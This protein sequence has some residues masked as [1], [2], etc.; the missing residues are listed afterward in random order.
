MNFSFRTTPF[1]AIS[2]LA[3]FASWLLLAACQKGNLDNLEQ[4][5]SLA[6]LDIQKI[7]LAV[8]EVYLNNSDI[9]MPINNTL[10]VHLIGVGNGN[11]KTDITGLVNVSWS[12]SSNNGSKISTNGVVTAGASGGSLTVNAS[13]A[14]LTANNP[15]S[16]NVYDPATLSST[17][18]DVWQAQTET[19][20]N[21]SSALNV[22]LCDQI[23]FAA[24]HVYGSYFWPA[25]D[26]NLD[27]QAN[28]TVGTPTS[29]NIINGV[30]TTN[31]SAPFTFNIGATVANSTPPITGSRTL[32]GTG[33]TPNSLRIE[34]NSFDVLVNENKALAV[35]AS[36][37]SGDRV[38]TLA[39]T[40][41]ASPATS[42][43]MTKNVF[44]ASTIG[45]AQ[46]TA[47]CAGVTTTASANVTQNTVVRLEITNTPSNG[48]DFIQLSQGGNLQL[49]LTAYF[50]SGTPDVN[51]ASNGNVVWSV[52]SRP[53]LVG[54]STDGLVTPNAD[55][56][57]G[58]AV[59]RASVKGSN[60]LI[61]VDITIQ[62]I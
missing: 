29:S 38:V 37:P 44:K 60:P 20:S 2:F 46:V 40:W 24:Y 41:T 61:Y 5:T 49:S 7:E 25:T 34:P 27:W 33:A 14:G 26:V 6:V 57:T 42:A 47:A 8:N 16:V 12:I 30:F 28:A 19:V 21:H 15:I 53:D 3:L 45:S 54:V 9:G 55:G 56:N 11:V 51:Y 50:I 58:Y 18:L 39:P 32:T 35:Y 48:N 4:Q 10:Q 23:E 62:V 59:V 17:V 13:Y 52:Y 43:T 31:E 22:E 36:Y 1:R